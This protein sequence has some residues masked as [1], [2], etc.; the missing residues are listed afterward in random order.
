MVVQ[1]TKEVGIR[2]VLG[3]SVSNIL[4][5]FS[6]EFAL[7]I[8]IAFVIAAPLAWYFM[9]EWLSNFV[10]R[11]QMSIG[12]YIIAILTSLCVALLAVS[13]KAIKAAIVNPVKSLRSE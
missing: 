1:K 4:Y 2:K 3:A 9:N 12:I 10:Y 7:L 6:K 13:Y 8:L 5:L 11:I